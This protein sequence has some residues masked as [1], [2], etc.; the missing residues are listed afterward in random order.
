MGLKDILQE[1][2]DLTIKNLQKLQKEYDKR[3][4]SEEFVGFNKVRHTY[5]HMGKLLGRLADYVQTVEDGEKDSY[6]SQQ[7]IKEKVIPD[8]L[9]Y[10][11]WLAEE[12]GVNLEQA[13]LKRFIGNIKRLYMNKISSEELRELELLANK[14]H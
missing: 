13:Y 14:K 4:I 2:S 7:Q 12:L 11:V 6:T 9:V 1:S 10:S 3:F 8:L 5:A